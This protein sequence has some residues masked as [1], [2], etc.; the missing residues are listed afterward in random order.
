MKKYITPHIYVES[1][2]PANILLTSGGPK[3]SG[4]GNKQIYAL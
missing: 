4:G 3:A 2:I 1:I